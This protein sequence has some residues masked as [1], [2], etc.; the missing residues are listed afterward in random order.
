MSIH[1][2]GTTLYTNRLI[3]E[4]PQAGRRVHADGQEYAAAWTECSR[5]NEKS[6][7][8]RSRADGRPDGGVPDVDYF[9]SNSSAVANLS[10]SSPKADNRPY[11]VVPASSSLVLLT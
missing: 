6:V 7:V 11:A 2:V 10:V 1:F 3:F 4:F 9:S 5:Q 8:S